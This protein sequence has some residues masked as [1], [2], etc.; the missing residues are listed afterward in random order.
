LVL[1]LRGGMFHESTD[2]GALS[3]VCEGE[4]ISLGEFTGFIAGSERWPLTAFPTT[5]LGELRAAVA[6]TAVKVT[7]RLP[8]NFSLGLCMGGTWTRY[9][10]DGPDVQLRELPALPSA[11]RIEA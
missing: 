4:Q 11:W 5:T 10:R 7:K 8:P 1:R 9:E 6:E 2:A 3:A